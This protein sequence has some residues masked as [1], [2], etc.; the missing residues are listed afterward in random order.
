M[1]RRSEKQASVSCGRAEVQAAVDEGFDAIAGTQAENGKLTAPEVSFD[2]LVHL[3]D[4]VLG[5]FGEED[6]KA[7]ESA[8]SD[9]KEAAVLMMQGQVDAA[10]NQFNAKKQES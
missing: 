3:A 2:V 10:M 1:T 7:V 4:Y 8:V 5:R 6:R 9:A